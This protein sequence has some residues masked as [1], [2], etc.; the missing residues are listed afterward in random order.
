MKNR[1]QVEIYRL[2]LLEELSKATDL[3]EKLDLLRLF[4]RSRIHDIQSMELKGSLGLVELFEGLTAVAEAVVHGSYETVREEMQKHD[5]DPR[6]SFAIVAIGK[7]GAR[8]LTYRSDLDIVYLFEH[9]EDQ[10]FYARLGARIISGLCLVTRE[11]YAYQIDAALRPSGNRGTLVSSLQ[12]FQE[13]H[14]EMGRTWERQAL[15]KARVILGEPSFIRKIQELLEQ[16]TYQ[17]Y[18]GPTISKEIDGLRMRMERELA[19]ERPG[20]YNLKTGRGG[21]VD[22]EFLVQYLQLLHGKTEPKVRGPNTLEAI[23]ALGEVH[24]LDPGVADRIEGAYLYYR[25][26]ETRLR[27]VMEY[28]TDEVIEVTPAFLKTREEVRQIYERILHP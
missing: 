16:I 22:I 2:A 20:R 18:D 15:I 17:A 4:T 26:L 12:A 19:H 6:G 24:I 9:P 1:G 28:P 7:F 21:L 11:G 27:L 3:E 5:P 14:R 13:Y 8:E 23:R 25:E 10:E